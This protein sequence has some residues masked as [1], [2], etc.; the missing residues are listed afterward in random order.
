MRMHNKSPMEKIVHFLIDTLH[1]LTVL[2][3][4]ILTF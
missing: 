4:S 2:V 1:L 3:I